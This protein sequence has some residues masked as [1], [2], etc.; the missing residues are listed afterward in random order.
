M[1]P[2]GGTVVPKKIYAETGTNGGTH[3]GV[4]GAV[5]IRMGSPRT[6]PPTPFSQTHCSGQYPQLSL[7]QQLPPT[8][9]HLSL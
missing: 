3:V 4:P 5:E 9:S 6:V 7:S 8:L 1:I 2:E